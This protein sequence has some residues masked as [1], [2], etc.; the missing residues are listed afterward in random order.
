MPITSSTAA[1]PA[2]FVGGHRRALTVG[3]ATAALALLG[4]A[5]PAQA[6]PPC[7]TGRLAF[8]ADTPDGSGVELYTVGADG[9]GLRQVTHLA[10]DAVAPDWSP[11]G[12]TLVFEED[13]PADEGARINLMDADGGHLRTIVQEPG[14]Y[15]GVPA[16]TPD[17]SKVI[18]V[19]F[20]PVTGD[21]A[22]WRMNRDG[23]HVVRVTADTPIPVTA[24]HLSP[25]QRTLSYLTAPD[26]GGLALDV[27][28]PDG[29]HVRH[30][31]PVSADLVDHQDW[32]PD[33]RR[34]ASSD[35][36]DHLTPGLSENLLT[37]SANGGPVT[38][39]T[40]FTGGDQNAVMGSYSPTGRSIAFR[41]EDHGL[42][43]LYQIPS[44]GGTPR[45]ILA[46]STLKPRYI[47]W[48]PTP[49]THR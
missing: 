25:D 12:R 32:S 5:A 9:T 2:S 14:V 3:A 42:F 17:G 20:D 26:F 22:I 13:L 21:N 28:R 40:H 10:G 38:H 6:V 36:H 7:D 29:S 49:R 30:L 48:G 16:F 11:D 23:S 41:L 44:S 46:L 15:D 43:G 27:S 1:R 18:F 37:V 19:R 35:N 47:D 31:I 8:V 39:L 33:G 45:P 24:P 4:S 34:L